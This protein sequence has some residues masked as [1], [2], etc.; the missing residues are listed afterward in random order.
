MVGCTGGGGICVDTIIGG[1]A[2]FSAECDGTTS[3]A[4]KRVSC[5]G[6]HEDISRD[7]GGAG[8]SVIVGRST[9][10]LDESGLSDPAFPG[11]GQNKMDSVSKLWSWDWSGGGVPQ[12][13]AGLSVGDCSGV[14]GMI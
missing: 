4:P 5:T 6:T 13:E 11:I 2:A 1:C 8:V 7:C 14:Y 9:R 10:G 3:R 12:E